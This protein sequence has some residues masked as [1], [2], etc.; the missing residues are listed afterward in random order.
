MIAA[1]LERRAALIAALHAEG[2][3][4]YR[5]FHG[6]TEGWPG[7]VAERY[8]PILL[9]SS[10]G[11]RI[12]EDQAARWAAEASEAVG[13]PLVGVWNHRGPP[14]CLPRCEVPPD[15]VGTELELAVDVRPRHRGN[16]PLL[17]LDFRAG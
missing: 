11:A 13:T 5:L 1:A 9:V 7:V 10:W 8:G 16:D 6:A 17:F 3:T 4:C 14:P 15:P 2:T 12:A